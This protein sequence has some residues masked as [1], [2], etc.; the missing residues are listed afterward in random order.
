MLR[1]KAEN[2]PGARSDGNRSRSNSAVSKIGSRPGSR[3]RRIAGFKDAILRP[4]NPDLK[5]V[6]QNMCGNNDGQLRQS[7]LSNQLFKQYLER[8]YPQEMVDVMIKYFDF[9]L[10]SYEDFISEMERFITNGEERQLY[11]CFDIFDFNKDKFICYQDTYQAIKI[12]T[13]NFYDTDLIKIQE[14]F[15]LKIQ[16]LLV[17][18]ERKLQRKKP[19]TFNLHNEMMQEEEVKAKLR[20]QL[21]KHPEKEE[22]LCFEDFC[23][24]DFQGRPQMLLHFLDYTCKYDYLRALGLFIAPVYHSKKNSEVIIAEMYQN[25]DLYENISKDDKKLKYYQ[26]LEESMSLCTTE[27]I[28]D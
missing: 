25:I 27:N 1:E 2:S 9:K 26:E 16:G 10:G 13:D 18:P 8:K 5:K 11:F 3:L 4:D 19:S 23:R 22:A 28:Y 21:F 6:F 15:K 17:V 14:M 24:I 7:R 12:R 20:R